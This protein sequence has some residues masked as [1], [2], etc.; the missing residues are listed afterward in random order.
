M[1]EETPPDWV[2]FRTLLADLHDDLP[3]RTERLRHLWALESGFGQ[4]RLMIPGGHASSGAYIELRHAFV[5]G[6]FL[7]AILLSQC[8][9][10]NI[11]AANVNLDRSSA[12][13]HGRTFETLPERPNYNLTL[14][15][16]ERLGLL[17]AVEVRELMKLSRLRNAVAHFR[18]LDHETNLE[19]RSLDQRRS[20]ARLVYEDARFAIGLVVRVLA[21]PEFV[22]GGPK[23]E[24]QS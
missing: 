9:L 18:S 7:S 21:K 23:G 24:P 12:E 5:C 8:L 1:L 17:S 10:E 14:E 11:L 16:C 20:A 13:I 15:A 2:A 19:R 4:G 22:I 6:N 3:A